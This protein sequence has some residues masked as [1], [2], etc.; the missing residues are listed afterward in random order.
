MSS[1]ST[2]APAAQN[3]DAVFGETADSL[4]AIPAV[5]ARVTANFH[6]QSPFRGFA[7]ALSKQLTKDEVD[8]GRYIAFLDQLYLAQC[9]LGQATMLAP[10]AKK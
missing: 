2:A 10:P 9:V 3:D 1:S 5:S 7:I 6:A 8:V 4:M